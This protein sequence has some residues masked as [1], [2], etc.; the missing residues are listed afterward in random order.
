MVI[1]FY[2]VCNRRKVGVPLEQVKKMLYKRTTR[3]G[4]V[5][6]HYLLITQLNGTVLRKLVR[7]KDW[8]ELDVPL[9]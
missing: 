6:V 3:N 1:Q 8:L 7:R 5:Q 2:D 4:K 9:I